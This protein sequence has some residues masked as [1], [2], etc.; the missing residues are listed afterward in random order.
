MN[1]DVD[2]FTTQVLER[3]HQVPVLVDFWADWC[4]PCKILGPVLER[5]AEN[6]KG[7]WALA[8]VDTEKLT[9]V[10]AKYNIRSIPNVKLF[11]DGKVAAEFVGALPETMVKQWLQRNLPSKFRKD[12]AQAEQFLVNNQVDKAQKLLY[13]VVQKEPDNHEARVMLAR[14]HLFSDQTRAVDLIKDIAADSEYFDAAEAIRT[15]ASVLGRNPDTLPGSP[16]RQTYLEAIEHLRVN[17]FGKALGGFIDVI[18]SERYYDDD[19]S[20]RACIAI[21]KILGEEHETTKRYRRDFSRALY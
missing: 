5:L 19:G 16:V 11:V 15:F 2:N 12:V 14:T 3:S 4:G 13:M 17:N 6:S 20:R 9:D 7:R 18:R 10:A 8:K 21:F 1:Y